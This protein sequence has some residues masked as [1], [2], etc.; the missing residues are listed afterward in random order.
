MTKIARR[1]PVRF[2]NVYEPPSQVSIIHALFKNRY[3][4]TSIKRLAC[5][6]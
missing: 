5:L 6:I 2:W 1:P 3:S 4:G